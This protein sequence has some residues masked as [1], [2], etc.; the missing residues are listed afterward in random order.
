MKLQ[1]RM[2][3]QRTFLITESHGI[4]IVVT[5]IFMHMMKLYILL[6][7]LKLNFKLIKFYSKTY[8]LDILLYNSI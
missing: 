1:Q 8:I 5:D 7:I 3:S 6:S 2:E 4:T